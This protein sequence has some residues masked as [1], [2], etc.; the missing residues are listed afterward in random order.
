MNMEN[1]T[2]I[3]IAVGLAMDAFAVSVSCGLSIKKRHVFKNAVY[4]GITFGIFQAGMA[5]LGWAAGLLFRDYIQAYNHW[6]AFALLVF[7]GGK[8]LKEAFSGYNEPIVLT[9]IITLITLAVATSI[10][11]LA[12]GLS[13]ATLN[14][15]I[16]IPTIIIGVT[17]LT[18]SFGGVFLG[19]AVRNTAQLG[20]R[21]DIL[22]GVILIG[23]G[24]K[25]L[26]EHLL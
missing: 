12:A 10:D 23:I 2:N 8:M 15:D 25:I 18:F 16:I 4:A 11:A 17:A 13:F 24:T 19:S 1:L 3:G 5:Y 9:G 14:K 21:V 26:V 20:K 7:I 6:V 22:G